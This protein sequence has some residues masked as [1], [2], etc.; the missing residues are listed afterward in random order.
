MSTGGTTPITAT[1]LPSFRG[2]TSAARSLTM[3]F[4]EFHCKTNIGK[5]RQAVQTGWTVNR[6]QP[7]TI[8]SGNDGGCCH[9]PLFRK[10]LC[11]E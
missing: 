3:V 11:Y 8:F 4:A 2:R 6:Q 1:I 5:K 10:E 7:R 9:K